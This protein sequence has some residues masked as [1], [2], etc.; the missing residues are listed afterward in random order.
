MDAGYR[1]QH[2]ETVQR[3]LDFDR[4]PKLER[5]GTRSRKHA[6]TSSPEEESGTREKKSLD[7]GSRKKNYS[8]AR[9]ESLRRSPRK[10]GVV[11]MNEKAPRESTVSPKKE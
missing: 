7:K 11:D 9:T 4:V 3:K 6:R 8:A 10:L 2:P 1:V 5:T